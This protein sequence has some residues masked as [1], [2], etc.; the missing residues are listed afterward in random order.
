MDYCQEFLVLASAFVGGSYGILS[1]V[2][3]LP[4]IRDTVGGKW[5][6]EHVLASIGK[7]DKVIEEVQEELN[8]C[9]DK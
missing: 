9:N 7:L 8:T 6:R 4:F 1:I 3:N 5:L 2:V